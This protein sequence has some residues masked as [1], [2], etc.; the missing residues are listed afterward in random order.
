MMERAIGKSATFTCLSQGQT[1]WYFVS[2]SSNIIAQVPILYI[3]RV[4][5]KHNGYYYCFGKYYGKESYFLA[6]A[7]LKVHG[8]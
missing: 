2:T 7:R 4:E 8:K 5:F 6:Q 3:S 1:K